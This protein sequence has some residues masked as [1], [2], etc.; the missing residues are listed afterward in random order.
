M[1][2]LPAFLFY[3]NDW[4]RDL[5][6]H[7]LEIEGAWIRITC[8]LFYSETRGRFAKTLPQIAKILGNRGEKTIRI[9]KYLQSENIANIPTD[10]SRIDNKGLITIESRR[11]VSD[12][13]K[14][15]KDRKRQKKR[16]DKPDE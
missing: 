16:R 12:E 2:K 8:K 9:L 1:G 5:E 4:S 14:R 6:E 7:P 13:N 10:L 15:E 11:M 3:P